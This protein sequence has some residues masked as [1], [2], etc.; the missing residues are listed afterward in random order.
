MDQTIQNGI[1]N[2]NYVIDKN[3]D[4]II[5]LLKDRVSLLEWQLTE[6][7]QI[8]DFLLK[9]QMST[10]APYSDINCDNNVL[11]LELMGTIKNK[12]LI[13]VIEIK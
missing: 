7:T 11:N 8:I 4:F 1:V 5:N 10:I 2:K 3:S 13:K 6:K 12:M 9:L